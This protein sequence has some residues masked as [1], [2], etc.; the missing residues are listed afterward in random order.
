LKC[1]LVGSAYCIHI[2]TVQAATGKITGTDS[3][4]IMAS[5]SISEPMDVSVAQD[6]GVMKTILEEA[7]VGAEGPPPKG[8]VVTAHYTG[9]L[10]DGS[11]F[12]SSRD[13][14]TAFM[15][16]IG[17]GQVIQGWDEGFASMKVGE[18]AVLTIRSDYGYGQ[19]GRP[20]K[21]PGGATLL[22]DVELL[23][24]DPLD[25]DEDIT[26][27]TEHDIID[28]EHEVDCERSA[29]FVGTVSP[30]GLTVA[31]QY[32]LET[33][34][35]NEEEDTNDSDWMDRLLRKMEIR[36]GQLLLKP[37]FSERCITQRPMRGR[38]RGQHHRHSNNRHRHIRRSLLLLTT[39]QTTSR[40]LMITGLSY[41]PR[42]TV[43]EE[44]SCDTNTN[45]TTITDN[46]NA[47]PITTTCRVIEGG[48][49]LFVND[50]ENDEATTQDMH[51]VL[52]TI[53][54]AM[55]ENP[56]IFLSL[57]PSIVKITYMGPYSIIGTNESETTHINDSKSTSTST[58]TRMELPDIMAAASKYTHEVRDSHAGQDGIPDDPN[59]KDNTS[60][61]YAEQ[62]EAI[63]VESFLM[64]G[65]VISVAIVAV[66][67]YGSGQFNGG[68]GHRRINRGDASPQDGSTTHAWVDD[69]TAPG[70]DR[71]EML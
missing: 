16:T 71:A 19:N 26:S 54:M 56:K 51:E 10:E 2:D 13:R 47:T 62:G 5:T 45:T 22:F 12:D 35:N 68:G 55:Q 27:S 58:R 48:V 38:P 9:T 14:G 32:Q 4:R 25:N 40:R 52:R 8:T 70:F 44:T 28:P 15:F 24:F 65:L 66:V 23:G 64:G 41:A 42:E 30:T 49:T 1:L 20:P 31:Y 69:N 36:I 11:K 46:D 21:I 3:H 29:P 6:G 63:L 37:V 67:G 50:D 34:N 18:H 43:L 17:Q 61:S 60:G 59:N 7:P 33:T 57:D 39:P 53:Q